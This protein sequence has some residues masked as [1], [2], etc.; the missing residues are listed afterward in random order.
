LRKKRK[1]VKNRSDDLEREAISSKGER[2]SVEEKAEKP[3][4]KLDKKQE[5]LG[6]NLIPW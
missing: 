4:P 1:F 5:G 6:D 3:R 2:E